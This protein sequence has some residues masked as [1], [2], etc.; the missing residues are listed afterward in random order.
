MRGPVKALIGLAVLA[1]L[2]VGADRLA[3][4]VAEDEAADLLVN[5]GRVGSPPEVTIEGFPFLT[6]ALSGE[7]DE[8]RLAADGMTVSNGRDRVAL[9]SFQARMSGVKVGDSDRRDV[10]VRSGSGSGLITY[11]DLS[12]LTVGAVPL[13]LEYAGPG[14]V[15]SVV[16]GGAIEGRLRNEGNTVIVDDLQLTGAA[17]ALKGM[18]GD[19]LSARRFTMTNLPAGL[20]LASA[21]PQSDGLRLEFTG[22]NLSL[23]G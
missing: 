13:G 22:S 14:R 7:F 23:I 16:P 11:A 6:Q 4:G 5:S 3:V 20:N 21:V 1:G 19:R 10:T 9:H 2:L 12:K 8:V 17:A 18:A 15:K